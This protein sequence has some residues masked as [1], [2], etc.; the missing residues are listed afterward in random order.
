M[1]LYLILFF[2]L[3]VCVLLEWFC[4]KYENKLYVLCWLLMTAILCFRFGQGTDYVTYHA[5]YETI[6]TAIDISQGYICGFYPEVG[7]RLLSAAFK[8]IHAPFWIFTMVLGL[9]EML[10]LHRFLKKY[11]PK[12]VTGLFV[13]YPVLF[14]VYMVSGLRQGL[15]MCLFLSLA[16]PYYI[17]KKWIKYIISILILMSFH[18]MG[19]VW[20]FLVLVYYLSWKVLLITVGFSIIGGILL[21]IEAI[22]NFVLNVVPIY[23][24]HVNEFLFEGEMSLFAIAERLLSFLVLLVLYIYYQK[25]GEVDTRIEL[26]M[27]AYTCGICFYMIFMTSSYYAS[28]YAIGFKILEVVLIVFFAEKEDKLA[29]LGA[30]F[31]FSLTLLMGVKNLNAM[32]SEG[33]YTRFGINLWTYPYVSIFN[34][35]E[36]N[37][38]FEYDKRFN[39]MYKYTVED[40]ELW[41][42]ED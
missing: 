16:V 13:L 39:T 42:I 18:R 25:K 35:E 33:G 17:E 24:Y 30:L 9:A 20:L 2:V 38:Y 29:K 23:Q 11:V 34:Q 27:K 4:P 1:N 22:A 10:L 5:I 8:L 6:S 40:Q 7:W 15:A 14:L 3:A 21:Q 28:R 36:I 12:K 26:F 41:R 32:V 31:F 19:F 37:Q